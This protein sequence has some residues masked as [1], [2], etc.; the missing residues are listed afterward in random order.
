[1]V[2]RDHRLYVWG[3][4]ANRKLGHAGFNPDGT[5]A[6]E[7]PSKKRPPGVAVRSALRDAVRRPRFVYSLLHSSVAAVGLGDEC[8]VIV[9]GHGSRPLFAADLADLVASSSPVSPTSPFGHSDI[10]DLA[11]PRDT[12]A[13]QQFVIPVR[14]PAKEEESPPARKDR[15]TI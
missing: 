3:H 15:V 13:S 5:E 6:G 7:H 11:S 1:M 4:P 9:T 2:T 8:T 12:E 10:T 14:P